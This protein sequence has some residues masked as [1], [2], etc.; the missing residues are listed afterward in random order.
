MAGII[1]SKISKGFQ[2]VIPAEV[3][4]ILQG[5]PGDEV[6]WSIIGDEVFI[7]IKK[8]NAEDP[9]K[10]LIG[11]FSSETAEDATAAIDDVVYGEK[12]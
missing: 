10:E 8:R 7:R 3:R 1:K 11:Q 4:A 5:Q 12:A 6:I 9:L 2:T